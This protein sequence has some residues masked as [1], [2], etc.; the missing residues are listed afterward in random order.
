M[1]EGIGLVSAGTMIG[2]LLGVASARVLQTLLFGVGAGDP[3]TFVGAPVLLMTV[4]ALAALFPALR[5][6]RVD[7]AN[8]LRSE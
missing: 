4:G 3:L 8:V 7:P 6:S 5:A 2:L 1:R